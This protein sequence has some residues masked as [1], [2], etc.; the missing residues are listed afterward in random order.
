V[1][2]IVHTAGD[3][4]ALSALLKPGSGT[5]GKIVVTVR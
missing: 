4:G 3:A 1:A 5:L 2:K